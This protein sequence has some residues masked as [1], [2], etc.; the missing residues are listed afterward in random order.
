MKKKRLLFVMLMILVLVSIT[1]CGSSSSSNR[2]WRKDAYEQGYY[3]GADG[4]WYHR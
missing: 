1:G 3:K 4:K 2:D